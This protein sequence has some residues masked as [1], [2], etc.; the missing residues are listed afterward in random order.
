MYCLVC[1]CVFLVLSSFSWVRLI[2]RVESVSFSLKFSWAEVSWVE[3]S[4]AE[5]SGV[6]LSWV[7]W[8]EL[9]WVFNLDLE[10]SW[11][12]V[13]VRVSFFLNRRNC[14]F[15]FVLFSC[16]VL[17][18]F[19]CELFVGVELSWVQFSF[20]F[21]FGRFVAE[22]SLIECSFRW[23]SFIRWSWVEWS[24]VYWSRVSFYAVQCE[25]NC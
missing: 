18:I 9:S 2:F 4:W 11:S 6:G 16:V 14:L 7:V 22:F 21:S 10:L 17:V 3:V 23:V 25:W 12:W 20:G 13:R 19:S 5:P 24:S 15:C 1:S 8:V